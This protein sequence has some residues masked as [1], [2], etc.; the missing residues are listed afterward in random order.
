[1]EHLVNI[2]Y[3]RFYRDLI[4]N[5][6]LIHEVIEGETEDG[7]FEN[8]YC[9]DDAENDAYHDEASL[10]KYGNAYYFKDDKIYECIIYFENME[11]T[12]VNLYSDINEIKDFI[13]E[14]LDILHGDIDELLYQQPWSKKFLP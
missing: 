10:S 1:M 2:H 4:D 13:K 6:T 14:L 8:Y 11:C 7:D 12:G 5:A 3:E 9:F